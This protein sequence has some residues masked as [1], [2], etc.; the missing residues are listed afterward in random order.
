[1]VPSALFFRLVSSPF[2]PPPAGLTAQSGDSV[3]YVNWDAVS[4][5]VTYNL[6]F[7]TQPGVTP[8]NYQSLANGAE[9][10]GVPQPQVVLDSQ[11]LVAGLT[12]YFVA[13]AVD[14]NGESTY[15]NEGSDVFGPQGQ[16]HGSFYTILTNGA[17][18]SEM[19]CGRR[20]RIP[21]QPE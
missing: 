4:N 18:T 14:T 11:T 8:A 5:A 1:M 13:T 3:M 10:Q 9:L 7:A 17:T 2:L 21:G 16:V 12:Y 15:S 19:F 6:Y 20:C